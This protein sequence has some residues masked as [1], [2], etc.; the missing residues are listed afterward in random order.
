MRKQVDL[1]ADPTNT[2]E[3][4]LGTFHADDWRVVA[5]DGIKWNWNNVKGK[6]CQKSYWNIVIA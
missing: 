4:D 5:T 3:A 6:Q 1:L 2:A